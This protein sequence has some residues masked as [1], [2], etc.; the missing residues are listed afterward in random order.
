MNPS[1]RKRQSFSLSL[2]PKRSWSCLKRP[3]T[4]FQIGRDEKYKE[5]EETDSDD[6]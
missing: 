2:P 5:P 4:I 6:Y 1:A 3:D